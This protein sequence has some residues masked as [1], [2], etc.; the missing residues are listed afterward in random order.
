MVVSGIYCLTSPSGK[1]YIGQS[2]DIFDRFTYYKKKI[3]SNN[4]LTKALHKYGPENFKFEVLEETTLDRLNEREQ[5]YI[6]LYE[7][8]NPDKGYN[9]TYGGGQFTPTDETRQKMREAQL[10]RKHPEEVKNKISG[11]PAGK[12]LTD[13]E[14]EARKNNGLKARGRKNKPFSEEAKKKISEARKGKKASMET[15]KKMSEQRTGRKQTL[16]T[17]E[18]LANINS[19]R[20]TPVMCL[21]TGKIYKSRG[22]ARRETGANNI[23]LCCKGKIK[24][25]GGYHWCYVKKENLE[26]PDSPSN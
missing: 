22:E 18:K 25:S 17:K 9:K 26:N 8:Y 14:K 23:L 24:T 2:K 4:H 21:E 19:I 1:R 6:S 11:K 13:K 15:R 10:G 12:P 16:K 3:G 5:Y 7:S 20:A